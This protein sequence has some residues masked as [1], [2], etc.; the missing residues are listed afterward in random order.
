MLPAGSQLA[1]ASAGAKLY[2]DYDEAIF[3][4]TR[5]L[6]FN[7]IPDLGPRVLT[8]SIVPSSSNSTTSSPNSDATKGYSGPSSK[9]RDRASSALCSTP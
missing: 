7:A 4:G 2:S 8:S 5:P 1:E 3:D 6:V 9:A